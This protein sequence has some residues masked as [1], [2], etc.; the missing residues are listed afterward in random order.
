MAH[1]IYGVPSTINSANL[2]YFLAL[3]ATFKL[4]NYEATQAFVTEMINLHKGQGLDIY[5]RDNAECP[6]EEQYLD[7][8]NDSKIKSLFLIFFLLNFVLF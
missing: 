8:V 1:S 6:T 3:E 4:G 7:M 5:W 2:V